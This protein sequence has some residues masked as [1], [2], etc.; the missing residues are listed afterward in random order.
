MTTW[1]GG[2]EAYIS[3]WAERVNRYLSS[4]FADDQVQ[5]RKLFEAMNYSLLAGGK[6]LRPV[7]CIATAETLDASPEDALPVA[8]AIEMIHTY[9]LIHDDLPSLDN[10][11]LRRGRPT[12]HKV[13]GEAMALLAGDALL[14]YAFEQL[15]QPRLTSLLSADALLRIIYTLAHA[16][17]CYGMVGGQVADVEGEG[18][19][20]TEEDLRFIHIHKTAKLIQAAVLLG[21]HVA[22]ADEQQLQTLGRFGLHLGL[23]YQM[24]DDL[25]DVTETTEHLG[26][27]AGKDE[28]N[29]KLTYPRMFGIAATRERIQQEF[30]MAVGELRSLEATGVLP[31]RL[32]DLA[33]YMIRRSH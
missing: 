9:S 18:R 22:L 6:R 10:D 7:L 16:A 25:L 14:T 11:D 3:S 29:E 28:A 15:S 33:N 20:G 4:I 23:A 17:G 8:A 5:P 1:S 27:T 12:N 32:F 24:V 26:K 13:F 21:A 31:S 30:D 19:M 2:A